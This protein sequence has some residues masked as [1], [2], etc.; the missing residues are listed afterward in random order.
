MNILLLLELP[1]FR[2]TVEQYTDDHRVFV[3]VAAAAV[4]LGNFIVRREIVGLYRLFVEHQ[5]DLIEDLL[6]RDAADREYA[7]VRREAEEEFLAAWF[8]GE[9]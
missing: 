1:W 3:R 4:A 6:R 2:I 8:S 5:Y 7:L 9:D